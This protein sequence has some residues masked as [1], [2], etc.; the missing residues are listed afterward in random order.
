MD[1]WID[2]IVDIDVDVFLWINTIKRY[3]E[4]INYYYRHSSAF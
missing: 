1:V 3:T 4:C 2:D